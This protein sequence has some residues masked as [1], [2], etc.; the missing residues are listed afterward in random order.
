MNLEKESKPSN[1]LEFF[2]RISHN[3][4]CSTPEKALKCY[5]PLSIAQRAMVTGEQVTK[6]HQENL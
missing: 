5:R 1:R 6:T 2:R 4:A 3:F